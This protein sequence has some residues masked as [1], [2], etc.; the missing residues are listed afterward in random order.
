MITPYPAGTVYS[1]WPTV[2][3]IVADTVVPGLLDRFLAR[4]AV[5]G[6]KTDKPV[7]PRRRDNLFKT[8]RSRH[9]T[10]G[11]FS[12]EASHS[13]VLLPAPLARIGVVALGALAFFGLGAAVRS[14]GR[15]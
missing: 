13:A 3:T 10:R 12:A 14:L 4:K 2:E 15:S 5:D 6:Q 7:P 9:T 8:V 11:S 1:G